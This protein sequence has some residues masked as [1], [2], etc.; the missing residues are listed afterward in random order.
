MKMKCFIGVRTLN[1]WLYLILL[2]QLRHSLV[3]QR[4]EF[5]KQL[6]LPSTTSVQGRFGL[7]RNRTSWTKSIVP[8]NGLWFIII[9]GSMPK[10]Q[11]LIEKKDI[12]SKKKNSNLRG[13]STVTGGCLQVNDTRKYEEESSQK[14]FSAIYLKITACDGWKA[15][16]IRIFLIRETGK[17]HFSTNIW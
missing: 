2:C 9:D 7:F 12:F 15:S 6:F 5:Q 3:F 1:C 13:L 8:N 4:K 14:V 10:N 11:I 16:Q 17:Y